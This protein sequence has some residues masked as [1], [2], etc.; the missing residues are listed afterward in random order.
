MATFEPQAKFVLS[1]NHAPR[2]ARVDFA[3][4][5]RIR[6]VPFNRRFEGASRDPH[7]LRR[8]LEERHA[9]MGM[10][11]RGAQAY[12]SSLSM[13]P[14]AEIDAASGEYLDSEDFIAQWIDDCARLE[15][16]TQTL[17]NDLYKNFT[18]WAEREGRKPWTAQAF[19]RALT[20]IGIETIKTNGQAYRKGVILV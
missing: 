2:L 19:G 4:R 8:L 16:S 3:I 1:T 10:L 11:V 12:A 15:P 14:C 6:L 13:P 5:R 18:A 7:I 17:S 9:I 20:E